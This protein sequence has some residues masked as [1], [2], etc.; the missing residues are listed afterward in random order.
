MTEPSPVAATL[1]VLKA[2]G[3]GKSFSGV[4]ALENVDIAVRRGA[5]NALVGENGAGKSTLM[6][7]LA[8]VFPPDEG[9][10]LLDG[11][12]VAFRRPRDAQEVGVSIIHQE[13]HLVPDLSVAENIFLG[14]EPRTRWGLIDYRKMLADAR[15]L[16][17]A[18]DPAIDPRTRVARLRVGAQQIVEIAKAVS[19]DARVLIMDEPTSAISEQEIAALFRLIHALKQ[20]GVGI[21]YITHKLTELPQIADD[22]TVLRDGRLVAARRFAEVTDDEMVRLMV[23]RELAQRVPKTSAAGAEVLAIRG[24]SLRHPE[25]QGDFLVRDVSFNVRAGEV[26]GLFG[27][28]GAGRTELLQTIF[29]LHPATSS[30]TVSVAGRAVNIRS[31]QDAIEA[32]IALAPEDRKAEGLVLAMTVRENASLA[33][34]KRAAPFGIVQPRCEHR[35]VAI[36]IDRL[37]V[38]TPSLSTPIRNLSGGNQQKVVLSKWLA[39][40]PKVL[41]LDEPTRGIDLG[42]KREIYAL[43]DE[44]ARGGLGVVIVSSELPEILAIAD[45]ILVLAEG[46]LTAEFERGLASEE[47][48]LHAALPQRARQAEP[49]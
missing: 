4:R 21:I 43:V 44:L 22:I 17:E 38:K 10:I 25:R 29:G 8:G 39:T 13:L 6:N 18:L 45:R 37:A 28:M 41:L 3:I 9:E 47:A 16:L 34:L 7:I 20:R 19:F 40:E 30:G 32:G 35:T 42:A 24:V 23:G 11:R 14:R 15:R 1:D 27:L 48:I 5:L 49:V 26:V 36:F 31:P 12:P 2:H 46:Q 33:C